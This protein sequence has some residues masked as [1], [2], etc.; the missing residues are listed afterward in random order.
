MAR[1]AA[2]MV[3]V[4]ILL[5]FS[6]TTGM[7]AWAGQVTDAVALKGVKQ[8]KGI[9]L[10]N[11]DSPQKTALY[12]NIIKDTYESMAA[13]KVRPDFIIVFVGPTVRFLTTK[14]DVELGAKQQ[15][16]LASIAASI[17]GLKTKGVKM[18]ICQIAT[19]FFKVSNDSLLPE[20]K[21]VNN[22]FISLIG[23]QAK[24]FSLVPVF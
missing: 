4:A 7:N 16:S 18:E 21:L 8:G 5:V 11:Q 13:Q 9:F 24:G 14:P 3:M 12:L 22:G 19:N 15:E 6:L 17:K 20:L 2:K 23:Y 1:I 10:I